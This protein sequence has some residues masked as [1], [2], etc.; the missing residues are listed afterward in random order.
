MKIC[1]LIGSLNGG[2]AERV[3]S[4]LANKFS[5]ENDVDIVVW[6]NEKPFYQLN[7]NIRVHNLNLTYDESS[8]GS[9]TWFNFKRII[10]LVKTLRQVK[11]VIMI[12]F[13][14]SNNV[15]AI[16]SA[17]ICG[18]PIIISERS[19]LFTNKISAFW[20]RL[21][22]LSYRFADVLALQT[23]GAYN[24]AFKHGFQAK[25][26]VVI[27]NPIMLD[28]ENIAEKEDVILFVGR[29]S[30]EKRVIDLLEAFAKI[31]AK[32]K[33]YALWVVGDG[34]EMAALKAAVVGLGLNEKVVFW[35]LQTSPK[36]FY[37][38]AKIFVLPSVS[39]G[40]PNVLLEAMNYN[41]IVISSNC[42]M[43]PAEI[44]E[45]GSNGFL[46]E[47]KDVDSLAALLS[48]VIDNFQAYGDIKLRAAEKLKEYSLPIIAAEWYKYINANKK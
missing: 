41:N 23:R 2:G 28:Q 43:G 13:I 6:N 7:S 46:Y 44:I 22:K 8:S 18:I 16:I 29:L 42:P 26:N 1:F 21:R 45:N 10:A 39:E 3:V 9:H 15:L 48:D 19:E 33:D 34:P 30:K 32:H 40:F 4:M 14:I 38:K 36:Q 20:F 27:P 31:N 35:G 17:K 24:L 37:L 47:P 5:D 11:P 25:D 12:S